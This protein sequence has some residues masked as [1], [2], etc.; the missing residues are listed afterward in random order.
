MIHAICL[1]LLVAIR[2]ADFDAFGSNR[3]EL[4]HGKPTISIISAQRTIRNPLIIEAR[5]LNKPVFGPADNLSEPPLP[6][7]KKKRRHKHVQIQ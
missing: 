3:M 7:K 1:I 6:K 2:A 5:V 4:E